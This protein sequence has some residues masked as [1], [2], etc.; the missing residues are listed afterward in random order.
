MTKPLDSLRSRSLPVQ[1]LSQ[2]DGQQRERALDE[3]SRMRILASRYKQMGF[4]ALAL[5][6]RQDADAAMMWAARPQ[7]ATVAKNATVRRARQL[8]PGENL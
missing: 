1:A 6:L 7:R 2:E 5:W 8:H 4:H 3:A